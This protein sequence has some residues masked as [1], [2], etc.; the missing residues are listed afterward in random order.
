MK[1][2]TGHGKDVTKYV[3]GLEEENKRLKA[4]L[5]ALK[6]TSVKMNVDYVGVDF[7]K[8]SDITNSES[9][10]SAKPRKTARKGKLSID[11]M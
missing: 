8:H 10:A 2:L 6:D 7:S 5:A 11:P 9:D 1:Y 3:A 4:E